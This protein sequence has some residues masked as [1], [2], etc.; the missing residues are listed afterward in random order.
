[1]D[2]ACGKKSIKFELI[3]PQIREAWDQLHCLRSEFSSAERLCRQLDKQVCVLC[4][5]AC[6]GEINI[7]LKKPF[8]F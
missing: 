8:F 4:M 7:K 6:D 3:S 5:W 2:N 1:M